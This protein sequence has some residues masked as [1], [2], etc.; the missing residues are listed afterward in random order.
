METEK[1]PLIIG[2]GGLLEKEETGRIDETLGSLREYGCITYGV[3]FSAICR[4]GDTL[5]C[6]ISFAWIGD[7]KAT[8]ET[9]LNDE[10]IDKK[11]IGIIASSLGATM[12]DYFIARD[13]TLAEGLGPYT[14]ISPFAR[15]NR[16]L[17]PAIQKFQERKQDL[18]L[19]SAYD[20]ERGIKRVIPYSNLDIILDLDST[21][22]LEKR[23]RIYHINP[24][25][26][27]G[28]KDDRCDIE[29]M[30]KRHEIL[31]GKS[32]NLLQHNCGHAIPQQEI[33]KDIVQFIKNNFNI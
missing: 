1:R 22:E 29:A 23:S 6:P 30:K 3:K 19:S 12:M 13:H 2:A 27:I 31:D 25:T 32:E 33:E 4:D 11:R 7:V 28:V 14:A 18:D 8:V 10:R 9:A 15:L 16:Q 5:V 21:A 26:I 24:L 20:K 17:V